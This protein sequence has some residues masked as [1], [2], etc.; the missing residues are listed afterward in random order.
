MEAT[1]Q[2]TV[3]TLE[4]IGGPASMVHLHPT[5]DTVLDVLDGVVYV[6]LDEDERALIPGD[7][8][9]IPAGVAYRFWNAG[10]DD[11]QVRQEHTSVAPGRAKAAFPRERG[12]LSGLLQAASRTLGIRIAPAV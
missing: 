8:V 7:R 1:R 3:T 6:V 10:D 2:L 9:T 11:A 12:A 5:Q 4:Q